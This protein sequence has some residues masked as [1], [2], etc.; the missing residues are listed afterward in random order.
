[1]K[2]LFSEN[3]TLKMQI[4][5]FAQKLNLNQLQNTDLPLTDKGIEKFMVN[6]NMPYFIAS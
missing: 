4:K 2:S 3:M 6:K 1:M 5:K